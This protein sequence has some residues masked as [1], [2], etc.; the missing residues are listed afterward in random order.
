MITLQATSQNAV[1]TIAS[2]TTQISNQIG[3]VTH[4]SNRSTA[5]FV[6]SNFGVPLTGSIAMGFAV[7]FIKG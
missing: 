7:G 1:T 6:I 2:A 5:A 4:S 3:N